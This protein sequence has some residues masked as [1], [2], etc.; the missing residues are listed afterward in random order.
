[1]K[2]VVTSNS[3]GAVWKWGIDIDFTGTFDPAK[4]TQIILL[5]TAQFIAG[6]LKQYH[7]VSAGL[8]AEMTA[9]EKT[10]ADAEIEL[11][12][13]EIFNGSPC[14]KVSFPTQANLPVPPPARGYLVT[15]ANLNGTGRGLALS[16]VTGWILFRQDGTV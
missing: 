9:G 6:L 11:V 5:D 15:V 10:A 7:K 2:R 1:M 14:I 16:T 8:L 4:Y 13:Q 3:T 12:A